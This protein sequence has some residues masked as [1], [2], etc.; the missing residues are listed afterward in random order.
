MLKI[1]RKKP[2]LVPLLSHSFP[3]LRRHDQRELHLPGPDERH[4]HR[5]RPVRLHHLQVRA[6]HLQDQA[7]LHGTPKII[8]EIQAK[9]QSNSRLIVKSFDIGGPVA[10]TV[11]AAVP[12][13]DP[14]ASNGGAVG[15]CATDTFSVTSPGN[16]GS[17]VICGFNTGQHSWNF[18]LFKKTFL[19][20]KLLSDIFQ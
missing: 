5:P 11:A 4:R 10:G 1:G 7:G 14:A 6:Q 19:E 8:D 12:A 9:R 18:R 3:V 13:G 2:Q 17:P 16:R 20:N 15:D